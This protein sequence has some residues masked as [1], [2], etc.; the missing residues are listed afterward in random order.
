MTKTRGDARHKAH[1]GVIFIAEDEPAVLE[2]MQDALEDA[3]YLVLPGRDG[4]EALARM[5]G[6]SGASLAIVDLTMPGMDGWDLITRMR[7]DKDLAH[8]PILVV[9]SH[10]RDPIKGADRLLRKPLTLKDLLR[11]VEELLA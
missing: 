3:G 4:H 7:A 11:A 9:S 2:S 6:V 5:H 1:K 8:I 10:G